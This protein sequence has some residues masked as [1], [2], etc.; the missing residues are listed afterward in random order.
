M[1]NEK[2]RNA[3]KL[4]N[5]FTLREVNEKYPYIPWVEYI[6]ALLPKGLN[7]DENEVII[8][9]VPSFFDAL[10]PLLENTPKRTIANYMMWRITVFSSFFLT[11]E[12]RKRQLVY[13][14]AV[15]G[16][17]EQEPRWK[18]C[19]DITSG[20]LSIS[21]GA[22][23]VRKYFKED[24]KRNAL[25]MVNGIR[26]EFEKILNN[27][28]WMDDETRVSATKKLHSMSTHIGYPDEIMNNEKIEDYY[29]N[30][31]IDQNNYLQSVLNM[32]VFGTDYAFNK[33][34]K[35][36]NKTDWVT[37]ARPAIVNAFYS[38]IENSIRKFNE[39]VGN[40]NK[41]IQLLLLLLFSFAFRIEFPAGILQGQFFSADRPRYM[42][43]GAIGFVI[44]HEITHGFDDQ[45]R[46]FDLN[47]N[48][49]DWWKPETKSSY[50]E[51][52]KCIIDQYGN[53][54]EP[55]TG[56]KVCF[57][58]SFFLFC[59]FHYYFKKINK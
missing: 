57:C 6:N 44:G 5:P 46:Q 23:Y 54:T 41:S 25:E 59:A 14:T 17:Q 24:S 43:Y 28:D 36:V 47:G 20:S 53:Y 40:K 45:G 52:A 16:K 30:L 50:L 31:E 9:S 11:E 34:R 1:P 33:L 39:K 10:G 27:V 55:S 15:S 56:L 21:V 2:R 7:V 18:E 38:S 51:K 58:F 49:V 8:V 42:N 26:K 4:Y 37:H 12:L 19:I 3:T 13:S 32:N 22:L 29:R 48:L 35:P